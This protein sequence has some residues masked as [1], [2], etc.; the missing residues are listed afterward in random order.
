MSVTV[1]CE[2]QDECRDWDVNEVV[3]S[4]SMWPVYQ[5]LMRADFTLFDQYSF[6]H[7]GPPL[8]LSYHD[9]M[10]YHEAMLVFLIGGTQS[11]HSKSEAETP[12]FIL[13][14]TTYATIQLDDHSGLE[15]HIKL[16]LSGFYLMF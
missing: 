8:W 14:C 11:I 16:S 13:A 12:A 9:C 2:M 3:F 7:Q 15:A 10:S 4:L 5:P 1:L 6:E